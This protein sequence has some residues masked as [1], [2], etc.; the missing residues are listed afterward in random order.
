MRSLRLFDT[1]LPV[2]YFP[3]GKLFRVDPTFN[4][5]YL[6]EAPSNPC[7]PEQVQ[8]ATEVNKRVYRLYWVSS[9]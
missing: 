4:F 2:V 5:E 7:D 9:F 3:T 8:A 6:G 1:F